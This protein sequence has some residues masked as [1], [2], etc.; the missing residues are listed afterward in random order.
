[1]RTTGVEES[2]VRGK[3]KSGSIWLLSRR[4]LLQLAGLIKCSMWLP[5]DVFSQMHLLRM[6]T[7]L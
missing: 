6:G 5:R 7:F 4:D 3:A 2:R 1:M